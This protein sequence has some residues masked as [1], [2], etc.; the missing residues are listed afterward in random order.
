M[1]FLGG[2][3]GK[4]VMTENRAL[5]LRPLPKKRHMLPVVRLE[6]LSLESCEEL[7]RDLSLLVFKKLIVRNTFVR[8]S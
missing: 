6:Q 1:I 3:Y 7:G 2:Y 5:K 4:S 8:R